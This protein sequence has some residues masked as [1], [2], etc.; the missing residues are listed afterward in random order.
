M[1]EFVVASAQTDV[2]GGLST[3]CFL[4][5]AE[6]PERECWYIN[7]DSVDRNFF[8]VAALVKSAP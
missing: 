1:R 3:M 5:S 8:T 7:M 6:T 2:Q 4:P